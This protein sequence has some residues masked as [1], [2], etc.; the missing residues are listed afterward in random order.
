MSLTITICD[1]PTALG[2]SV[3]WYGCP[4]GVGVELGWAVVKDSDLSLDHVHALKACTADVYG[5]VLQLY[6]KV[7]DRFIRVLVDTKRL[8]E[9][10][11]SGKTCVL[12]PSRRYYRA[13]A[14]TKI[15]GFANPPWDEPWDSSNPTGEPVEMTMQ[16]DDLSECRMDVGEISTQFHDPASDQQGL[17]WIA[18]GDDLVAVSP[19]SMLEVSDLSLP[20]GMTMMM[21]ARKCNRAGMTSL[22]RRE[23]EGMII[24]SREMIVLATGVSEVDT[25][26]SQVGERRYA[27]GK[28][29]TLMALA[30]AMQESARLRVGSAVLYF[31]YLL[32]LE[33]IIPIIDE[34]SEMLEKNL[35]DA[36]KEL[37]D[38]SENVAYPLINRLEKEFSK[39]AKEIRSKPGPSEVFPLTDLRVKVMGGGGEGGD[40]GGQPDVREGGESDGITANEGEEDAD[41]NEETEQEAGQSFATWTFPFYGFDSTFFIDTVPEDTIR[42]YDGIGRLSPDGRLGGNDLRTMTFDDVDSLRADFQG[43]ELEFTRVGFE[44]VAGLYEGV[45]PLAPYLKILVEVFRNGELDIRVVCHDNATPFSVFPLV[46]NNDPYLHYALQPTEF[47][48]QGQLLGQVREVC[49][50]KDV[51]DGDFATVT[52]ATPRLIYLTLGGKPIA[53]RRNG[54]IGTPRTFTQG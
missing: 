28:L 31:T 5:S 22:E 12:N 52:F 8:L 47:S 26:M 54:F 53:L 24:R 1:A 51:E 21:V 42:W 11:L 38:S 27:E 39:V 17:S 49:P 4:W 10:H 23:G 14:E 34:R 6:S 18:T 7:E 43:Q 16:N 2:C 45:D 35:D 48:S 41:W 32:Y 37:K 25:E 44:Y 33:D 15:L 29:A 46:Q 13:V 30:Y 19:E 36:W 50:D 20:R 3:T 9:D 40:D